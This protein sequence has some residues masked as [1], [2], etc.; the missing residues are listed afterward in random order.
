M[1]RRGKFSLDTRGLRALQRELVKRYGG[2][3]P[4]EADE[5]HLHSVLIRGESVE[6]HARWN[7][8]AHLAAG[9]GWALL[10]LKPFAEGNSRMALAAMVTYLEMNRLHLDCSEVE[11]TAMVIKAARKQIT[12]RQWTEWVIRRVRRNSDRKS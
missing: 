2:K 7:P 10:T 5:T 3:A 6:R 12:E 11:E 8:P 4:P 1:T 9:Y